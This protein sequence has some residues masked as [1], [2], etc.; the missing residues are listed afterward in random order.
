MELTGSAYL[1]TLGALSMTFAGFCAVVIVIR[2]TIGRELSGFHVVLM[3]LYIESGLSAAAFCM[4]PGL[5]AVCGFSPATTWRAS[6]AIIAIAMIS[7]GAAYPARRRSVMAG[8]APMARWLPIVAVSLLMIATLIANAVGT[9][10]EPGPGP[11]AIAASWTLACGAIV[12]VLA[13]NAFWER[14]DGS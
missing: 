5:L 3:R 14:G 13:L 10:R 12:F 1:Y 4:L 6:S 7:Y 9:P 2:Q 11:V 8:S